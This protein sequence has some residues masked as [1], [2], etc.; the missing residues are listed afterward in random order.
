MD[1]KFIL[2][3]STATKDK[4]LKL[5]FKLVSDSN[6]NFIFLNDNK[7]N[8]SNLENIVYSNKLTF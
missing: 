4:L 5:G 7:L 3:T 8:F 6:E 2:T 1:K